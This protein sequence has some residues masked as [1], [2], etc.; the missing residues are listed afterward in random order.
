MPYAGKALM[1][2]TIAEACRPHW[3]NYELTKAIAVSLGE[4]AG[5]VGSWHDNLDGNGALKSRDC[6]LFQINI[7]AV[8]VDTYV[9]EALRTESK[10]EEVWRPVLTN[11]ILAAERL[12]NSPVDR[13][14]TRLW[15]PWYAYTTGWATFPEWWVWKQ[16]NGVPTGPWVATGRYIH[17]AIAGQ[18]NYHIV[19][20]KDWTPEQA[21]YYAARYTKKFGI[22]TGELGVKQGIL[23]WVKI[24]PKPLTPP[25]NGVGPRPVP[26][27]GR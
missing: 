22:A 20:L 3:M 9:E 19:I 21:L 27:D 13:W 8:R 16:T 26:N 25:A 10:D 23:Q 15:Q 5:Y 11:N 14:R 4:S 17:K 18:M 6:G 2:R 7:P 12:Y 1:P 24:P